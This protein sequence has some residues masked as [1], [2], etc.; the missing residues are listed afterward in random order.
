MY[1]HSFIPR[2]AYY[3]LPL[4]SKQ[5]SYLRVKLHKMHFR[6]QGQS[7]ESKKYAC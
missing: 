4:E 6:G 5:K 7:I 2:D 1:F 3:L